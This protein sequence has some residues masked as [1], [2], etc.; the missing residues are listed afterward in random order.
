MRRE[1][2]DVAE[3]TRIEPPATPV[4]GAEAA[5]TADESGDAGASAADDESA[6]ADESKAAGTSA[7][8]DESE[9]SDESKAAGASVAEDES[10]TSAESETRDEPKGAD[11]G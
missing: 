9:T 2:M 10:E 4:S 1:F 8:D 5:G 3:Q 11:V 6:T 7:A